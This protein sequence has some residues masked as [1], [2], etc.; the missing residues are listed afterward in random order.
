M[1]AAS[2]FRALAGSLIATLFFPA[3]RVETEARDRAFPSHT[4]APEEKEARDLLGPTLPWAAELPEVTVQCGNTN[5]EA[6]VKLYRPDGVLDETALDAFMQTVA[7]NGDVRTLNERTVRLAF[8]AAYHFKSLRIVVVSSW[9]RGHGPHSTG[10]ALDFRLQ[11]VGASRLAAYLRTLPRAGVGIYTHPQ[12]QYVHL[13]DR[14]TSFHWL[15]A[16][17]PGKTWREAALADKGRDARDA[18]YAPENDL[19]TDPPAKD[20]PK[21]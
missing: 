19:P 15:D 16:S 5:A 14:E 9:R 17:P 7:E 11:G 1:F 2:P 3:P 6:S 4:L 13:D 21:K 10:D 12:T 20:L 8:K 18:A